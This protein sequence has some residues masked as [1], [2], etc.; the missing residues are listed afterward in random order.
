MK[1]K[2]KDNSPLSNIK[3]NLRSIKNCPIHSPKNKKIIDKLI[4]KTTKIIKNKKVR[5]K[6]L[7]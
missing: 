4:G 1:Y 2:K 3:L 7:T 6:I 5:L